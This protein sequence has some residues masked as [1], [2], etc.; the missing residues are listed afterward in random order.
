MDSLTAEVDSLER[1]IREMDLSI[2]SLVVQVTLTGR[3]S[4]CVMLT[5][6]YG[7]LQYPMQ[8]IYGDNAIVYGKT[9]MR[10][11]YHAIYIYP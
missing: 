6:F 11:N 4:C 9:T 8:Y 5:G 1:K 2:S 3:L 7:K 10:S